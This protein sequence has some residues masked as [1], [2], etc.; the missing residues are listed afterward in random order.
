[1]VSVD[2]NWNDK[3]DS[4]EKQIFENKDLLSNLIDKNT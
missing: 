4:I 1:M 2:I 3:I